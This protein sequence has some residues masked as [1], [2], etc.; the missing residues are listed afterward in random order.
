[1]FL[2]F[3]VLFGYFVKNLYQNFFTC[4]EIDEKTE[5]AILKSFNNYETR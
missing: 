1:M 2:R 3:P 5:Y 4:L